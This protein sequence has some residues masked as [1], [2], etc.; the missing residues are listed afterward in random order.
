VPE[1]LQALFVD[2]DRLLADARGLG[3]QRKRVVHAKPILLAQR[4]EAPHRPASGF[5]VVSLKKASD[6]RSHGSHG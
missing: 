5:E 3:I 4:A 2:A 6:A 1:Q